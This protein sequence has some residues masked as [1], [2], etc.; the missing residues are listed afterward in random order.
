MANSPLHRHNRHIWV[1]M[2][3]FTLGDLFCPH[4][5]SRVGTITYLV[6]WRKLRYIETEF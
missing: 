3:H 1:Y 5:S 4:N 2:K 6:R